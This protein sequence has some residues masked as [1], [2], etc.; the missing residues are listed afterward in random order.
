VTA[1]GPLV[2]D[3]GPGALWEKPLWQTKAF[4]H[5]LSVSSPQYVG[6]T[7]FQISELFNF[8][9]CVDFAC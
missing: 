4:K 3:T 6:P 9:N 5:G 7:A 1:Q 2:N 8:Y